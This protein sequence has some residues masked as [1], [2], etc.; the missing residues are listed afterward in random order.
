MNF[1]L[2]QNEFD[3]VCNVLG[4][5]PTKSGAFM[6]LQKLQAQAA[7]SKVIASAQEVQP[8]ETVQ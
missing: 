4:E 3:F 7:A 6:V 5:L 1:Q 2:E 8:E